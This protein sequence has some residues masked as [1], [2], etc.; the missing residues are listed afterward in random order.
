MYVARLPQTT[1]LFMA[2][3][4]NVVHELERYAGVDF[5]REAPIEQEAWKFC[6]MRTVSGCGGCGFYC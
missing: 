2:E 3:V 1:P 5:A 4:G 6:E